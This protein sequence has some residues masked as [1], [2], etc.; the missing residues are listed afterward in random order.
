M[1]RTARQSQRSLGNRT[2]LTVEEERALEDDVDALH[3]LPLRLLPLETTALD[4]ARLIKNAQLETVVELFSNKSSGSGQLEIEDLPSR[5][6]GIGR[7]DMALIEQ[8]GELASFDVYTLRIE[9]RRLGIEVDEHK[10]LRLSTQR[11]AKL[12]DYMTA[13]TR[14]LVQRVFGD[15][16]V[17]YGGMAE[18]LDLFR[19][20]DVAVARRNMF[21]LANELEISVD[22]LPAFLED[23]GDLYLSLSYYQDCLD[24]CAPVLKN[25]RQTIEEMRESETHRANLPLMEVCRRVE[26]KIDAATTEVTLLL[27]SFQA[28]SVEM[29]R[30]LTATRFRELREMITESHVKMGGDLCMLVVKSKAWEQHFPKYRLGGIYKKAQ[31]LQAEIRPGIDRVA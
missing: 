24:D 16:E 27:K 1:S 6:S 20:P 29:W 19:S 3:I 12:V 4:R 17:E 5:F 7:N 15:R 10:R 2:T 30:N 11:Q 21:D 13:F 8:V 26:T 22:G 31:I 28:R 18:F 9:L 14:P 23:Y 25:L